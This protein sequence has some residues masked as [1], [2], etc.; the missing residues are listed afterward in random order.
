MDGQT[1]LVLSDTHGNLPA[2]RTVFKWAR[3]RSIAAA[4]FLGDGAAD[5]PLA[6]AETG[7][8]CQWKIVRG[9]GD[10][11][12]AI[13]ETDT[14]DFGGRR[15]L[16]SHGH[17]YALYNGYHSLIAAARNLGAGTILFGHL[18]VPVLETEDGIVLINPGSLGRP[19]SRAGATFALIECPAGRPLEIQFRGIGPDGRI[20]K[21]RSPRQGSMD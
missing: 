11:D 13:P 10:P 18:H 14:L 4:V 9:N 2:L 7:F 6:A 20:R 5:L 15:F 1:L 12:P 8:N 17:R 3:S 19:R 16:L 21:I